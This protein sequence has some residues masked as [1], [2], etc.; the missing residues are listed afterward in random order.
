LMTILIGGQ[1]CASRHQSGPSGL[2][3][4]T[5]LRAPNYPSIARQ[6][7]FQGTIRV[8]V[9]I[10]PGGSLAWYRIEASTEPTIVPL[11][12]ADIDKALK[13]STYAA[14]CSGQTVPLRFVFGFE[15]ERMPTGVFFVA[16]DDVDVIV[17]NPPILGS[18]GH[19]G[20][21]RPGEGRNP[22]TADTRGAR[23]RDT[24][25]P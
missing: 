11:F 13:T 1:A 18:A 15:E 6:A 9:G 20:E 2:P 5:R 7:R 3:C 25:A 10:G 4:V 17:E 21:R 24:T 12:R 8:A 16:P 19:S 22:S 14:S 23:S